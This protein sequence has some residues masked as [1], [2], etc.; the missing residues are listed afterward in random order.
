MLPDLPLP[1]DPRLLLF[2]LPFVL[3]LLFVTRRRK[4]TG[5]GYPYTAI[6]NLFTANERDFLRVLEQAAPESRIFGKVRLAD[7]IAVR[8]GLP[9]SAWQR[10]FNRIGNKHLD[11]VLCQPEDLSI[12]CVIELDDKSHKRADRMQ[13]DAFLEAA[14]HAA[15]VT[16]VRVKSR[17]SY[18]VTSLRAQLSGVSGT[19][20]ET[21]PTPVERVIDVGA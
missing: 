11:F 17:K 3:F 2:A 1:F 21:R 4:P 16:L 13:R 20:D 18:D 15:Q 19:V 12:R 14:L 8:K 5:V 10:A 6:G 7:V 9:K